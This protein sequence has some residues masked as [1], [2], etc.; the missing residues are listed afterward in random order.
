MVRL[1]SDIGWKDAFAQ[2]GLTARHEQQARADIALFLG[3]V[4]NG[5]LSFKFT[6][7]LRPAQADAP[8]GI[9]V[10]LFENG[11]T[12][13]VK[14]GENRGATLHHDFVVR[15]WIDPIPVAA[16]GSTERAMSFS[17][18]PDRPPANSGIAAFVQNPRTFEVVQA[19]ARQVCGGTELPSRSSP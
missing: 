2:P 11:L 14:A 9:F 3:Q 16:S 12:T 18:P 15:E 19:V 17:L 10:A 13:S 7:R 4:A 5:K 6:A 8:A 1:L